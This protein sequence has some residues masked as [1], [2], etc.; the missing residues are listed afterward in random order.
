M[1]KASTWPALVSIAPDRYASR[2]TVI[3]RIAMPRLFYSLLLYLLVPLI[4]LRLLYR[5]MRAP[6]YRR[7]VAERFGFFKPPAATGGLWVHA[8]S[9]GESIA[10]AP[11]IRH[12][13]EKHPELPVVVSCMT[14]TGSERIRELFGDRVF[15]VYA[16][17]DLPD[18][19]SR[20][21]D[22]IQPRAAVIME[23]EIWPNM[24]CQT[25]ARGIPV[26]L[27]NARL[28]ERSARGY[29]RLSGLSRPVMRAMHRIVAQ[30]RADAERFAALGVSPDA[31]CVSGSI[32]FDVSIPD[33]LRQ[34][35]LALREAMG[36]RPTW[37]AAS[38]H[39][40]E[41][42]ILLDAHRQLLTQFP[43]ALLI[44]VP[45]HP[46]RFDGVARQIEQTELR[47][48]RRSL[49]GT[50]ARDSQVLLG[51]TM[52]ELLLLLGTADIAFIGGSLIPRGGHNSLEAAAWGLP[53]LT[54][55][56]DFNFAE[57]SRLLQDAGAQRIVDSAQSL[58]DALQRLFADAEQRQQQGRHAL[59]VVD[60]NRGAL[61]TL[62]NEVEAAL[63]Q[64]S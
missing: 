14:P 62:I 3:C 47:Y 50:A 63:Q 46:E 17:Y 45:R 20:F 18:A 55:P 35:A 4:L 19:V 13:L 12:F 34:Q 56:S 23:T 9:V 16:P 36:T 22:R 40:G 59:S 11:L 31:L 52:G 30:G 39:D 54:G 10:A 43:D 21:L 27:A 53:V 60:A 49:E 26:L 37:I 7:R 1:C 42:G 33:A 28:S 64:Q 5:A 58:F 44:L 25:S 48:T 24:V 2:R 57:I 6:D 61:Q 38:T 51:D 32:K 29:Q 8:V 41:D 15:H